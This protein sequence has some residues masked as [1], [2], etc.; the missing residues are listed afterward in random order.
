MLYRLSAC[1]IAKGI[2]EGRF[3]CLEV[4]QSCLGRI[5]EMEGDIHAML[6][7][8][9]DEAIV[10]AKE[11]DGRL[12]SG[13]DIGPL[14]GVPII[15]KDN[16]CTSGQET[17]C[18]SRI[19]KG[20]RPPYDATVVELLKGAGAIIL[21][22][23]NLDE[24][25]MGGSTENSAF[26]V[27][28]NPWDLERVPGGSS[29]G[30]AAAVAAGYVPLSL[31]SDTGGS[32]RQP[33]AFCGI[34]GL[35]PTY[36]R[37]SRYG[38]VAFASSLDQI[39]PFARTVEDLARVMEVIGVPDPK[40]STSQDVAGFDF[41]SA[42]GRTDLK[43]KRVGV[44]EEIDA[45]DYDPRVKKALED[46]IQACRDEGAEIVSISLKTAIEYGMACYYILAPAEASSNLARYDGVR[47]GHSAK[48]AGS[49]V[50]LYL[51][52]RREGFGEEVKRRILTGTYVLSAGFY[53]A[54]YLKAQKVRKAIKEEFA[55]AF[56]Q[57]DSI[58]L[59]SSPT[60]AFKIGEL[61][62][63]PMAMYMADVFTIPVNMAGLPGLSMN[64]GFSQ[65]GLPLGVQ[66]I[67][68]RWGEEELIGV[69]AVMERRFGKAEIAHR[70]VK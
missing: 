45:Y 63:D 61:V 29:G 7:T 47:Y 68:P 51:K 20:W 40:D 44:I 60:P 35:K 54:Y 36:G 38:L 39:G 69:A 34:Y 14:G 15:L 4:V 50:D 11:L 65:E 64:V 21:G 53:D 37:V 43:G 30:S 46:T 18:A 19:L 25:A 33:A 2:K 70:E 52:T 49:V 28:A 12:A 58:V 16:M 59:P 31:G 56:E 8:W 6:S 13:E 67:G 10:R 22:K 55:K 62:D 3:S 41:S 9:R 23:A 57:V 1:D 24:F 26:G 48:D 27:T 32:I 42:L 5:D 17:T 66:F